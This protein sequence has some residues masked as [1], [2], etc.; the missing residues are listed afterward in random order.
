MTVG[1]ARGDHRGDYSGDHRGGQS[2]FGLDQT[3]DVGRETVG[4]HPA[5]RFAQ[6]L[7]DGLV[8]GSQRR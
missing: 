7:H 2:V 3:T 5:R 6:A 4:G 1:R 8:L